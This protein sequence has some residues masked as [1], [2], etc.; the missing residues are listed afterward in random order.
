MESLDEVYLRSSGRVYMTALQA[1]VRVPLLQS[2]RDRAAGLDTAGFVSG[3][4]GSP[5]GGF[6]LALWRAKAHLE[7]ANVR[8]RPGIN[9][10]MAAT[11]VWGT[12][13]IGFKPTARYDG[14]FS[15]WYGKGPGVD[16]CGDVFKHGNIAGS[17]RH[18]GVL[19][20]AGDDHANKSSS[21]PHQ[22]EYAFVAASIPVLSPSTVQE[23]L[24]FGLHG[25]A[26]SRYSG[27]WVGFIAVGDTVESAA[28]VS[29][30]DLP[31]L[32]MPSDFELP[33]GGL[34]IRHPDNPHEQ[35]RRLLVHKLA[36]AQAY[37][38]ANALD[39][40]VIQPPA[41]CRLAIVAAGKAYLDVRQALEDLELDDTR[42]GAEGIGLFKVGLSWPLES[43]AI[44]AFCEPFDEVLV[45]EEKRGLIEDQ[46]SKI[47]VNS[48]V[49][50]RWIVGK[51]DEIGQPLL[52]ENGELSAALIART[53]LTRLLHWERKP[54]LERR[55]NALNR[56]GALELPA[57]DLAR[58]P[59]FCAGCPHN[60]STVVPDGSRALAGI[61]CHGMA[62]WAPKP[63]AETV[64]Q[65]GG[66]GANW[67]GI[68]PF[69]HEAHVFQNLGDGTYFHSGLLAIRAA[70]AAKVNVTYKILFNSAVAMTGGQPIDGTLDPASI[71]RQVHAEGVRHIAVVTDDT[72]RYGRRSQ[73]APG[74]SLH[75]RDQ[76][77][78]IQEQLRERP[79][80]S[81]LIY[82][83]T[84]AAEKRRRQKRGIVPQ[85]ERRLFIN[86]RVCEGCGD[87]SKQS[88]CIAVAPLETQLGRKRAIDQY[89]CNTD[90]SCLQGFC[91]SFVTVVGG[92]LRKGAIQSDASPD[93]VSTVGLVEPVRPSSAKPFNIM[94]A[95]IGGTG[96]ITVGAILGVAAQIDGKAV[97]VLDQT[98]MSQKNGSV[99]SH[100]RIS[101]SA[102]GLHAP[103]IESGKI[104]A[105]LACD[106]IVATSSAALV[107]CDPV[108]TQAIVNEH[109]A[110]TPAFVANPDLDLS[111]ERLIGTVRKRCRSVTML[112]ATQLA[113]DVTGD[114]V[115]ANLAVL[116]A[117]YQRGL[118]P[119]SASSIKRAIRLNGIAIDSN[120]AAFEAGRLAV[121]D[122][123][124]VAA[125]AIS[126]D[127]RSPITTFENLDQATNFRF[128]YL[129][130]YQNRRYAERYRRLTSLA[131]KVDLHGNAEWPRFATA[132]SGAFFKLMAYKDEYEVA[133]L[134]TDG[135]FRRQLE[136]NFAGPYRLQFHLAP[137]LFAKRDPKT[138]LPRKRAFG[139]WMESVFRGLARL[140]FLR[141]TPFDPFGWT[142]ERRTERRLITD[143][144]QRIQELATRLNAS[145][146][147]D[148]CEVAELPEKIRGYG[149]VKLESVGRAR[150]KEADLLAKVATNGDLSPR[151]IRGE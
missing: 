15:M 79:G 147:D 48:I 38:R 88:N 6:D 138:G 50:P 148:H 47:F 42:A 114:L 65:M 16:R 75:S 130:A 82:D 18:G 7:R 137:P 134:F 107:G 118:V 5:L 12:Q 23:Y 146:Y 143:Y 33:P 98:G 133:R 34:N 113:A 19:L 54:E 36:A 20:V 61:G 40:A 87:C 22:S 14:V 140:R 101:D 103:R 1:L 71:S 77:I 39:R 13:Q 96:V 100:V 110:P 95:G 124:S 74:T 21:F 115:S 45:I 11:A 117:A 89:N 135:D 44:R 150:R 99:A 59:F 64:V 139:P 8:F 145:N 2:Q 63:R 136:A 106:L 66:E 35:E 151:S 29:L 121:V 81:V 69:T 10:D 144:E 24:Q 28:S 62:M 76:I 84:C 70:V 116:G 86:E 4:R 85:P 41:Q 67:I 43:Q 126:H 25:I 142:F 93:G 109:V 37:A 55:L 119:V 72:R 127:T 105:L 73:F 49:R 32:S 131:S 92:R 31:G 132:V 104:D 56:P 112:N 128:A 91:P 102:A 30:D 120:L 17:A 129:I 80:V 52:P 57:H 78:S 60:S 68:A 51:R 111:S 26:L 3:Y 149:H 9:E 83:Q 125:R 27:C 90:F 97:T 53:I 122:S 123:T 94:V 108:R 46:L 141:G 58:G